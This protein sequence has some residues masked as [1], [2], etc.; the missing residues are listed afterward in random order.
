MDDGVNPGE[1]ITHFLIFVQYEKQLMYRKIVVFY[2]IQKSPSGFLTD[3][4]GYQVSATPV[5][6]SSE[7]FTFWMPC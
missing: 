2:P 7:V 1:E 5:G 3:L 6:M 4:K